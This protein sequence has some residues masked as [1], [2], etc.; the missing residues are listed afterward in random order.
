M[1][2]IKSIRIWK[3]NGETRIYITTTDNRQAC[4]YVTG[5]RFHKPNSWESA[6]TD[7]EM[8]R[9]KKL[10]VYDGHWHNIPEWEMPQRIADVDVKPMPHPK[11]HLF[12]R[13]SSTKTN[14]KPGH[15]SRCGKFLN[16]GEGEVVHFEEEEDVDILGNGNEQALYCL[17]V[18]DCMDRAARIQSEIDRKKQEKENEL[19]DA[20]ILAA[21]V[22]NNTGLEEQADWSWDD[23]RFRVGKVLAESDK[24][25]AR[26]YLMNDEVIGFVIEKKKGGAA[27]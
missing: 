1:A 16:P 15:C 2:E 20:R 8:Q 12:P 19:E 26:E 25:V 18:V 17:N 13:P 10:G 9:A 27:S 3:K 11:P 24:H 6:L 14:K 21:R 23:F 5:N 7:D 4:K 22:A